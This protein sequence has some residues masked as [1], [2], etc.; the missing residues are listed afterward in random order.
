[1]KSHEV[2]RR[3]CKR[4]GCKR[5]ASEL[6]LSL[7]MIH[8]WAQSRADGRSAELNPLD[9]VVRLVEVTG[10]RRVVEWLCEQC[11]G[12]FVAHPKTVR[13]TSTELVMLVSSAIQ[14][15]DTLQSGLV[16]RLGEKES[17]KH[18]PR[19]AKRGED[20]QGKEILI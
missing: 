2:W 9:R 6:G 12:R 17:K 15:L 13:L 7:S 16:S 10:D 18:F 8:K 20:G 3:A 4:A 19:P 1:M 5:V 14:N 11:G